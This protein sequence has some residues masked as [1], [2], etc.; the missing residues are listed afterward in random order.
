MKKP[1]NGTP[2][3]EASQAELFENVVAISPQV[4]PSDMKI[5]G[6]CKFLDKGHSICAIRLPPQIR[7]SDD[8]R[9]HT[10]GSHHSC[11]FHQHK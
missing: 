4:E 3:K 6:T 2:V 11:D 7:V 1:I 10:V 5:C 8:W 9:A